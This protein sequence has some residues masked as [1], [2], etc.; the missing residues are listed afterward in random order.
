[1]NLTY[2]MSQQRMSMPS[3]VLAGVKRTR[4]V[5]VVTGVTGRVDARFVTAFGSLVF[6]PCFACISIL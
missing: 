3:S 5:K 6:S 4:R 1:M 2:G